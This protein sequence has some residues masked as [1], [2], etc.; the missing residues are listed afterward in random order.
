MI[1]AVQTAE[2]LNSTYLAAGIIVAVIAIVTAGAA[3]WRSVKAGIAKEEREKALLDL[4]PK[5]SDR[6]GGLERKLT[7]NGLDTEQVGDVVKRTENAVRDIRSRLDQHIGAS[8]TTHEQ[9]WRVINRK[10]DREAV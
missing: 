4:V 10:Q 3:I 8:E 6:I 7:P 9:M 2:T 1:L 5:L